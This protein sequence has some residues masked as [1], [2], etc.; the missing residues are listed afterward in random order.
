MLKNQ[1]GGDIHKGYYKIVLD[2]KDYFFTIPLHPQNCG[3][4][5]FSVLSIH[6]K[7]PIKRY[8]WIVLS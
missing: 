4:F 7:D 5:T 3:R 8:Q 1:A 6:F 2:L